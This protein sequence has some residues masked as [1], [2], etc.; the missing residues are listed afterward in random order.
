MPN[1]SRLAAPLALAFIALLLAA[2]LASGDGKAPLL[3]NARV[4]P[5][6]GDDSIDYLFTVTYQDEENESPSSMRVYIDG[7][8]HDMA[9]VDPLDANFSD[10]RDYS[11]KTQLKTGTYA[12]YFKASDGS[13]ESQTVAQTIQVESTSIFRMEHSDLIRV[14][15]GV[16]PFVLVLVVIVIIQLRRI[17]KNIE[18]LSAGKGSQV[19][20]QMAAGEKPAETETPAKA[21]TG[22]EPDD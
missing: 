13:N 9:P 10:G 17:G 19:E 16:L 11:Y 12:F 15:L 21:E 8:A 2:Q 22:Q 4:T 6:A 7:K 18:R 14:G 20:T 5:G 3:K 1:V